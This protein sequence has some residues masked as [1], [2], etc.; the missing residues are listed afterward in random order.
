M[1]L[2]NYGGALRLRECSY[3]H[4][5]E[6]TSDRAFCCIYH[7]VSITSI[8][9]GFIVVINSYTFPFVNL[10]GDLVKAFVNANFF[11]T[12]SSLSHMYINVSDDWGLYMSANWP[13][14]STFSVTSSTLRSSPTN[15]LKVL[16]N[17]WDPQ[18]LKVGKLSAISVSSKCSLHPSSAGFS[19]PNYSG[20]QN[21]F[22]QV[23]CAPK[24]AV[25][26]FKFWWIISSRWR[27]RSVRI[28]TTV[29]AVHDGA[30]SSTYPLTV[31]AI[32]ILNNLAIMVSPAV[33]RSFVFDACVRIDIVRFDSSL[34]PPVQSSQCPDLLLLL[35]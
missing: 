1:T 33:K 34:R 11:P 8:K 17:D 30:P 31:S 32:E 5:C 19:D 9:H 29:A 23:S 6:A 18:V 10:P 12:A 20:P 14:F 25:A 22:L 4:S 2:Q 3:H 28:S 26:L 24:L 7:V 21:G 16:S 27:M 13:G 15:F 35:L